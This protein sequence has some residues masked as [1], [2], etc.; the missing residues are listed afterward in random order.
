MAGMASN[1]YQI[2]TLKYTAQVEDRGGSLVWYPPTGSLF[3]WPLFS[4][5]FYLG[6]YTNTK[7]MSP[8]TMLLLIPHATHHC[9][10]VYNMQMK[11][12]F[13]IY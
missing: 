3:S 8:V 12:H 4:R 2:G 1:T 9:W 10:S 6:N 5:L 13:L 7:R 11:C